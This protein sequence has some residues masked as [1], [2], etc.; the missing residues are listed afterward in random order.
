MWNQ[1]ENSESTYHNVTDS[2]KKR[3]EHQ[4]SGIVDSGF[5]SSGN[6]LTSTNELSCELDTS[7]NLLTTLEEHVVDGT[8]ISK[9][10]NLSSEQMRADSGLDLGLSENLSQMS[11]NHN[12]LNPLGQQRKKYEKIQS[13]PVLE[14][15]IKIENA[16]HRMTNEFSEQQPD[17]E[18][19]WQLY[20]M[21]D[22]DGDTQL[23]IAIIQGFF[24]AA[25]FSLIRMAPHPDLLDII[26]DDGQ[27]PLHLAALTRQSRMA[28][29][30]IIGGANP[31]LRDSKGNTALH[32]ACALGDLDTARALTD[33]LAT[34]ER[35]YLGPH[36]RIPAL[37]QDL[38]QRNYRGEMCL[39][40]A[41]ACDRVDLVR[42]LLRLGADLEAREGLSGRTAL[43]LAV[44]LRCRSVVQFLLQECRPCLNAVTYSGITAYQIALCLDSQ[45]AHQLVRLGAKPEP[46]PESDSEISDDSNDDDESNYMPEFSL[47]RPQIGVRV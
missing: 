35:N 33:P 37:P 14:P 25:A 30:L 16:T 13:E 42:L 3:T 36:R 20:Y 11:L 43:H 45:L 2:E 32:L 1:S 44:E 4:D 41:A 39:H 6:I 18:V 26:N 12:T 19:P 34:I 7:S 29:R 46:L 17:L 8:L 23:H 38:E 21:Q 22:E 28:R 9:A 15:I 40:I 31:S 5:L 27:A 10:E 24:E 47:L